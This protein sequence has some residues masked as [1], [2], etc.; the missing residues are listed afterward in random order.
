M[1]AS[2]PD[3]AE[4]V[5]TYHTAESL[6]LHPMCTRVVRKGGTVTN[7]FVERSPDGYHL[8]EQI[9]QDPPRLLTVGT[10]EEV[11]R[12]AAPSSS[13][14]EQLYLSSQAYLVPDH[15]LTEPCWLDISEYP[16]FPAGTWYFGFQEHV[17]VH[18]AQA[19]P[20]NTNHGPVVIYGPIVERP[21]SHRKHLRVR[22]VQPQQRWLVIEYPARTILLPDIR[23]VMQA[24][25][26]WSF[27]LRV[28]ME[29]LLERLHLRPLS[30]H[31]SPGRL[32][33]YG[34]PPTN[35]REAEQVRL[36]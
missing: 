35:W 2:T 16:E 24:R 26:R 7:L 15:Q 31:E 9:G 30:L 14:H 28:Q 32:K 21:Q 10:L 1:T 8:L 20:Y 33:V 3:D 29:S 36:A 19:S 4:P 22:V 12:F 27:W 18:V 34:R 5:R 6:F 25:H 23:W 17:H 11:N 13:L